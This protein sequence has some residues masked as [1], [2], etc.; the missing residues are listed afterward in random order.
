MK[1]PLKGFYELN[2]VNIFL[3]FVGLTLAVVWITN[4]GETV[5]I[6]ED[7]MLGTFSDPS[8]RG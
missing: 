6:L 5:A 4:W 1:K 2:D 3:K 7:Q 8:Q